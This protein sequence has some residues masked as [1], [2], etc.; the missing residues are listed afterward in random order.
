MK[1]YRIIKHTAE[2]T[3]PAPYGVNIKHSHTTYEVQKRFLGFLWWYNFSNIDGIVTGRFDTLR[4]AQTAI[5][6]YRVKR[7]KKVVEEYE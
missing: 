5:N 3:E 7:S 4:E 1:R 2:W 6:E